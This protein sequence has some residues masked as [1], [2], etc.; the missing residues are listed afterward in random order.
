MVLLTKSNIGNVWRM[1][2]SVDVP[3]GVV[4]CC[5][6]SERQRLFVDR[7]NGCFRERV[8]LIEVV[9]Y[10]VV[11]CYVCVVVGIEM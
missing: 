7:Y 3:R 8:E 1:L 5:I 2:R 11:L 10:P 6:F 4:K 9:D